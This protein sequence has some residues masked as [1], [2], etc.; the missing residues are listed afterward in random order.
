VTNLVQLEQQFLAHDLQCTHFSRFLLLCQIY[1]SVATLTDLS[2]D[3]EIT[4]SQL[5][6]PLPQICSFSS[7]IFGHESIILIFWSFWWLGYTLP[8][9]LR[10]GL[11]VVDVAEEVEVVVEEV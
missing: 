3:L 10:A 2:Q 9:L 4:M 5:C 11:T 6:S 1:L 7:Q 8:E